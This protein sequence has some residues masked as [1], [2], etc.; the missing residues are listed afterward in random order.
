MSGNAEW[1]E[2]T[3]SPLFPDYFT[4]QG[5]AGPVAVALT[6]DDYSNVYFSLGGSVGAEYLLYGLSARAAGG[7]IIAN[8]VQDG[9]GVEW[10]WDEGVE[11]EAELENF[12]TKWS[13]GGGVGVPL[14]GVIG[15]GVDG[16][17]NLTTDLA[18]AAI[19]AGVYTPQ[20]GGGVNYTWKIRNPHDPKP[21]DKFK[22]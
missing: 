9:F 14:A 20:L 12:L 10:Q 11:T 3:N 8:Q 18:G 15:P 17:V 4:V 13:R 21:D 1:P 6:I 22:K 16:V 19:E 2:F 5:T 7:W